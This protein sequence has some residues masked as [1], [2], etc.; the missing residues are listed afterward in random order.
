MTTILNTIRD[1]A[2]DQLGSPATI[3]RILRESNPIAALPIPPPVV[4]MEA[5]VVHWQRWNESRSDGYGPGVLHGYDHRNG[6][7][8][9]W[10]RHVPSLERIVSQ[11]IVPHFSCDITDVDGIGAAKG[12]PERFA[13]LDA[14]VENDSPEMIHPMTAETLQRDLDHREIR[15]FDP[16]GGDYFVRHAWDGRLFLSNAGGAHHFA[17]ARYLA[18][19]LGQKVP[20]EGKLYSYAFNASAIEE[21]RNEFAMFTIPYDVLFGAG[22]QDALQSF[23]AP[24]YWRNM[25]REYPGIM[26]IFLPKSC[27]RSMRIAQV[28]RKIGMLDFGAYLQDIHQGAMR[29]TLTATRSVPNV[30][31]LQSQSANDTQSNTNTKIGF[32]S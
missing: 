28:M 16:E 9:G 20:L 11:T 4:H 3:T 30:T 19:R 8:E 15:I 27:D 14:W 32:E 12:F 23:H 5:G 31:A 24:Y 21:L 6:L 26:V 29:N 1:F 10:A 2:I 13:E 17:A 22:L 18:R 25:P 7:R